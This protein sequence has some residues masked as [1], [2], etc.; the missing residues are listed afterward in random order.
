MTKAVDDATPNP[1][2]LITYTIVIYNG[3]AFSYTNALISDTLP[4]DLTFA[5]PVTLDPSQAGATLAH[6]A[7]GLPTLASG[8]TITAGTG[9]TLTFP[10]TVNLDTAGRT[11]TNTASLTSTQVPTPALGS[12]TVTVLPADLCITKSVTP[13]IASPCDAITYTL[14]FSNAQSYATGVVITDSV[15]V[16]V[17]NTSVVSSGVVITDTGA[18]PPYVWN[19]Q[20]LAPSQGGVITITGVLSTPLPGG[21]VFTNTATITTAAVDSDAGNNGSSAG[22]TVRSILAITVTKTANVSAVEVGETITYTYRVTNTGNVTLDPVSAHDDRL[23][24]VTL[25]STSLALDVGTSGILTYTVVEG[26]WPGPLTNTVTVSG[27]PPSGPDVTATA[28]ESVGLT[29]ITVTKRANVASA[30]VGETITYTYWVTNTGNVTLDPVSAHDD[31]LGAVALGS[32]SLAPGAGTS[33]RLTYTV[34]EGDRPG[35]LTNTVTVS[36]T[37][38][39]GPDVTTTA[40]ASVGLIWKLHLPWVSKGFA[41]AP[42]LVVESLV[43]TSNAVTVTIQ[44]QGN[45]AVSDEFWVDV[46]FDPSQAPSLNH[47]WNTIPSHGATWG[48][49]A[50]I[51]AGGSLVLTTGGDYYVSEYSSTPPLPVGADV[52]ALVDSVDYSTTYGAVQESNEDNNLAGPITSTAGAAGEGASVVDQG[53]AVIFLPVIH[54][55]RT[56]SEGAS[57]VGQGRPASLEGLPPRW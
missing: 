57:G 11:I 23:G 1:G 9:I 8:V 52:Y 10:V 25:G 19:V 54:F 51:P 2:Q 26:D 50:P 20:D 14:T 13:A 28:D 18:S 27:T 53:Q 21:H 12:A 33:G 35:P 38:P 39:S 42:D 7:S 29:S 34:V 47:P 5:G 36:G 43:A 22:V 41:H 44:N 24:A 3:D 49:T 56:Q 6:D 55:T 46:Y 17:T 15:P 32:T 16:S 45:V 37:P 31:R 40:D 30:E 48:V 4:G